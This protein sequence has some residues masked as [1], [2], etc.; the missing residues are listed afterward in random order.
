MARPSNAF[1][2][3]RCCSSAQFPTWI[4]L[5]VLGSVKQIRLLLGLHVLGLNMSSLLPVPHLNYNTHALRPRSDFDDFRAFYFR[6]SYTTTS[7]VISLLCCSTLTLIVPRYHFY[8]EEIDNHSRDALK[9]CPARV[10]GLD[11]RRRGT[12]LTRLLRPAL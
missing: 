2:S 4:W 9:G 8:P 3:S 5:A 1:L 11:L 7:F 10:P 12:R 6:S